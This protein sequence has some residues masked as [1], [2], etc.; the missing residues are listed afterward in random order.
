M[1]RPQQRI[2]QD[3]I[4]FATRRDYHDADP[5]R[6]T[7]RRWP[8]SEEVHTLQREIRSDQ[9]AARTDIDATRRTVQQV[10]EVVESAAGQVAEAAV[11]VAEVESGRQ[12]I[13]ASQGAVP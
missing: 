3:T 13:L 9:R 8:P 4:R 10:T 6:S 2:E 11:Q 5:R 1:A 7:A 12:R